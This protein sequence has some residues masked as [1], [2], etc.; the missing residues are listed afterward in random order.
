MK[1]WYVE[2][3]VTCEECEGWCRVPHLLKG[4]GIMTSKPCDNCWG[5]GFWIKRVPLS[6]EQNQQVNQILNGV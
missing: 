5:L 3:R 6:D 1:K 2:K 4:A